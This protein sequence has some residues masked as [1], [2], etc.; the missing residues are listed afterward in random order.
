MYMHTSRKHHQNIICLWTGSLES[1]VPTFPETPSWGPM[2]LLRLVHFHVPGRW[3]QLRQWPIPKWKLLIIH[4]FLG[5]T[6]PEVND[7]NKELMGHSSA[8]RVCVK[9]DFLVGIFIGSKGTQGYTDTRAASSKMTTEGARLL[10]TI[11]EKGIGTLAI[12]WAGSWSFTIRI[13]DLPEILYDFW[14]GTLRYS[15][16]NN[17]LRMCSWKGDMKLWECFI[18]VNMS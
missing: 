1:K 9:L 5:V 17:F 6:S 7:L 13:L 16:K 2:H 8:H 11:V 14:L 12:I 10:N 15:F 3:M 18:Y 4:R